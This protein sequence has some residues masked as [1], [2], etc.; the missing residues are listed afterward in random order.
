MSVMVIAAWVV[1]IGLRF[2][3]RFGLLCVD[4]AETLRQRHRPCPLAYIKF[5]ENVPH[6]PLHCLGRYPKATSN[7]L[8]GVPLSHQTGDMSLPLT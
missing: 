7:F 8:I 6:M 2:A 4:D 5:N 3:A 1:M